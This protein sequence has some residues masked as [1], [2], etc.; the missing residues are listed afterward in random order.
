MSRPRR[1]RARTSALA[2]VAA[3]GLLAATLTTTPLVA[4]AAPASKAP[5]KV[6]QTAFRPGN[7]LVTLAEIPAAAYQGGVQGYAGTR[8]AAGKRFDATSAASVKY[9]GYLKAKHDRLTAKVGAT[10]YYDYTVALNGFAAHLTAKQAAAL[11]KSPGVLAVQPDARRKID[12]DLSPAFLGLSGAGGLWSKVG[13]QTNAGKNVIVGVIDTGIWPESP[14]FAGKTVK[15]NK[16]GQ[17]LPGQGIRSTWHGICQQGEQFNSQDCNDKLIGARYFADGF[18]KQNIDKSDYLSP[19]DGDGHGSHTASTAAG[20]RV[21]G[22]VVDGTSFG[23]VSGMAPAAQVAAYKVCWTGK[24]GVADDGCFNSDSAAAIDQAVADGVDVINYSI[25]GGSESP[26]LDEV[27]LAFLFAAAAGVYNAASAGNSGPGASTL[28]HPSPWISTTAASTHRIS[29]KKLVLGN[30][31]QYI[32]ASTT[33][34]LPALTPMVMAKSSGADPAQAELCAPG[35]LDPAKVTGKL[36]VCVRG[37]VDRIAK[38]F[39]VKRAGGVGMVMINPSANSLNGDL[40]AVPSVH[41]SHTALAPVTAY[42]GGASPTGKIVALAPGESATQVPEIADFSS[43]GPST[44][45]GGD[46]LKPDLAAPG[47]DVLA[48]VAPP[49]HFGRSYDL[50]SGTSMASPHNAGLAALIRQAHPTWSPMAVKSALMTTA[51]D[52]ASTSTADGGVFAQGAGFVRPNLA[53]DP[54]VVFDHGFAD[55]VGYLEEVSGEDLVD[56]IEPL[57]GSQLN[58]ASIALGALAGVETV[59]R[60]MTNVSG[61]AETYSPSVSLPGVAVTFSPATVTVPAGGTASVD[62]TFTRTDAAADE[63]TTGSLTWTG[64]QGHVARMPLA[65]RPVDVAVPAEVT[66]EGADG[67]V[68]LD[69]TSGFNGTLG[70]VVHGLVG[71]TPTAESVTVGAF[72][73]DN[74]VADADTDRFE[75]DAAGAQAI[76]F[77]VD[78]ADTADLDLFVYQVDDEGTEVLVASSADGDAE[79]AVTLLEPEDGTYVAYVNGFGGDGSYSWT[80]WVVGEADAGNLTVT[81]ASQPVTV[82]EQASFEAQWSGLDTA[83][84]W[85]GVV[86]WTNGGEQVGS[87]VVSIG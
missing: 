42:V 81:P 80:Q 51:R 13:G 2:A 40:H 39:E 83:Q 33:A 74:P 10:P 5:A 79:E 75:V 29:E 22:V 18:V 70:T 9:R 32:G 48:A 65:V 8:P 58:Q 72:D 31:D 19:R 61:E 27:E 57:D 85:L 82:G 50:I 23:T 52:H 73:P 4:Q 6:V 7:Y 87:T 71:A 68:E 54:G 55:W 26:V 11:A 77:D 49:F 25:G 16:A 44:T 1:R 35:S 64:N 67:S 12:T 34:E 14:S 20:N 69:V 53:T 30:G 21:D 24:V 78:G 86:G 84:R 60:T 59:T 15:H 3:A 62:I 76:R 47:V 17:P 38:S 46:I 37:V 36:V 41:I 28:D 43:R 45:T 56:G 63:Y 66:G